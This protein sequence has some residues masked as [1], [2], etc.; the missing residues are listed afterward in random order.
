MSLELSRRVKREVDE[1]RSLF[2][3]AVRMVRDGTFEEKSGKVLRIHA[4]STMLKQ[5][6]GI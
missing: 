1:V 4:T 6:E 2:H 3:R 5:I